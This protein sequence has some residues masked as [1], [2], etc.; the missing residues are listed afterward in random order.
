[1]QHTFEQDGLPGEIN[2]GHGG[3]CPVRI[4]ELTTD[5]CHLAAGAVLMPEG[6]PVDLWLGA[7]GPLSG[8]VTSPDGQMVR[9]TG[10]IHPAIVNHFTH[11][12]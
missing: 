10:T 12:C 3:S 1:M 4:S 6:T 8:V 9:F 7:I 2:T 11:A 5:H